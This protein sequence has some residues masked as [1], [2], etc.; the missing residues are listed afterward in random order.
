MS[1]RGSGFMEG[2]LVGSTAEQVALR[3]PL[4]VLLVPCKNK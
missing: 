2:I 4:P 3:S 1:T